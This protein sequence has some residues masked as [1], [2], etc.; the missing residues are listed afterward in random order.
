MTEQQIE[1]CDLHIGLSKIALA[2]EN[3]KEWEDDERGQLYWRKIWWLIDNMPIDDLNDIT[4]TLRGALGT[5]VRVLTD[6][7]EEDV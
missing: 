7:P 3:V 4:G 5:T 1:F 6:K 2:M